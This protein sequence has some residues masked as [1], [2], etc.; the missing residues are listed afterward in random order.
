MKRVIKLTESDLQ[1]IVRKVLNEQSSSSVNPKGLKFG[2]RGEDV[3]KLQQKLIDL[4][5]LK[6]SKGPTGFFGKMT[7]GAL[8]KAEGKP[9]PTTKDISK[10]TTQKSSKIS[11]QELTV[12]PSVG[13][14]P[15]FR[16]L[17]G[18]V[19]NFKKQFPNLKTDQEVIALIDRLINRD[20]QMF[21]Q[22][23]PSIS[24]E[25][26]CEVASIGRRSQYDTKNIFIIDS[27]NKRIFLFSAKDRSGARKLIASDIIQDG[28]NKQKNDVNS[29]AKSFEGYGLTFRRLQAELKRDPTSDEVWKSFDV[30]KV[31]FLPAGVYQ[32]GRTSS[33]KS[34]A[35]EGNNQLWLKN[36]LGN[37]IGQA[38]HGYYLGDNRV[39]FMQK[40]L[41]IVKN[42]ND[43]KQIESF[44]NELKNSGLKMDFSY[45]CINV[46]ERF[47]KYL[48]QY[49][50]NSF[51][52]NIAEDNK[53]YLVQNT[54]NFFEKMQN[55][56]SCPSP[57]SLGAVDMSTMA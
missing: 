56:E 48:E 44:S 55:S 29:I 41:S 27:P 9:V 24:R 35:G 10:G 3:R 45:G 52:F 20:A 46:P 7:Q 51:V 2:D 34:D 4:K 19:S 28:K 32:G 43:A 30:N 49:G 40:A 23:I 39:G 53:N 1:K 57:K 21:K 18:M 14:S 6:L 25:G 13:N 8:D 47:T 17:S 11:G 42:P 54:E 31:R 26:A 15:Y 5:I 33:S 36:W 22:T 37:E 50:P 12:C 38:I 16:D